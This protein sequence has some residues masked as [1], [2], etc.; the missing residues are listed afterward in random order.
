MGECTDECNSMI[1][2]VDE[3]E[4]NNNEIFVCE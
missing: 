3:N 2:E 1:V 4:E